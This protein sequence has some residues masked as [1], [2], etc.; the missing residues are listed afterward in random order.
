MK[1]LA[2]AGAVY[3]WVWG[4]SC[5]GELSYELEGQLDR[6]IILFVA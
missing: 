4:D 2:I 1:K 5:G 3:R 6:A